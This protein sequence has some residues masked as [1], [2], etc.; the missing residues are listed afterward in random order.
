MQWKVITR[1]VCIEGYMGFKYRRFGEQ[2]R[3]GRSIGSEE[4]GGA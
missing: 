3:S 2:G 1:L 4:M